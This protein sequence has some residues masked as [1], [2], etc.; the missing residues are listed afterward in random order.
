[1]PVK[2]ASAKHKCPILNGLLLEASGSVGDYRHIG[3]FSAFDKDVVDVV[4]AGLQYFDARAAETGLEYS[5]DEG[6]GYKY[7]IRII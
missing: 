1:M 3:V 2:D 5:D 6:G 4:Q 7:T